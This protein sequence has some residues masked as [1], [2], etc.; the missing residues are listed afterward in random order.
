MKKIFPLTESDVKN[1]K[2]GYYTGVTN[3]PISPPPPPKPLKNIPVTF[4]S[5]YKDKENKSIF[6]KI[7]N[8]LNR[9]Y[10]KD[11]LK[12]II[13]NDKTNNKYL[14]V[15]HNYWM[16]SNKG[17]EKFII[18]A[19]SEIQADKEA[20]LLAYKRT[21]LFNSCNYIVIKL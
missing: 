7:T 2:K 16:R 1:P 13:I 18:E 15:L 9:N 19:N 5:I 11:T 10:K 17:F 3:K 4:E 21:K 6:S 20:A 8:I 12:D 14:I